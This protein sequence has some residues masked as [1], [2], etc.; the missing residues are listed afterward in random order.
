MAAPP[1]LQP[2]ASIPTA[3]VPAAA[4]LAAAAFAET[5]CYVAIFPGDG[6]ARAAAQHRLRTRFLTWLF[7]RNFQLR[8]DAGCFHGARDTRSGAL[9]AFFML[10][11]PGVRDPSI[12]DMLRI[13]LLSGVCL[14]GVGT[15]LRLLKT[16][17]Y[18]EQRE[19]EVLGRRWGKMVRLERMTVLPAYQRKG[20]GTSAL[21]A[22]L[23][24]V[25]DA[26]GLACVLST[27]EQR[28]VRFYM[29]L[30][31]VVVDES[32]VCIGETEY[33][34][35]WMIREPEKTAA[36]AHTDA[37]DVA[38]GVDVSAKAPPHQIAKRLAAF[39]LAAFAA[40]TLALA[41]LAAAYTELRAAWA[42]N[43]ALRRELFPFRAISDR[44]GARNFDFVADPSTAPV[45]T[46][47]HDDSTR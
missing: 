35:W 47:A 23:R 4:A 19:R 42:E 16:K 3:E 7:E 9:V 2:S 29:R 46:P 14:W 13:G 45:P 34:N 43:A 32:R 6:D 41:L 10:T 12:C 1:W 22:A 38:A 5:P 11:P 15:T 31:F 25:A 33:T 21:R 26:R 28:N 37:T 17:A 18:F 27:Q 44:A 40:L 20:V 39:R 8:V 24:K 36:D 30:G